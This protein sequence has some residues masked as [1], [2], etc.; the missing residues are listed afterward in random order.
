MN[1]QS[2]RRAR[3]VSFLSAATAV[4]LLPLITPAQAIVGDAVVGNAYTFTAK[5]QFGDGAEARSCTGSLVDA[6][7]V[8]TTA[9]CFTGGTTELTV[10]KPVAKTTAIVGRTD[11]A[12]AG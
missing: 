9:S 6:Q 2:S 12:A 4:G 7:W 8:L 3:A 11:L 5:I 1:V 10:S